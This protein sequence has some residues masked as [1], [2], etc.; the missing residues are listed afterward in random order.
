MIFLIENLKFAHSIAKAVDSDVVIIEQ[1]RIEKTHS[2]QNRNFVL[3]LN[4]DENLSSQNVIDLLKMSR[5]EA[6]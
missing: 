2:V 1:S 3:S 4:E 5:L 6:K